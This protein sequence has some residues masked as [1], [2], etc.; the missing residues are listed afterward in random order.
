MSDRLKSSNMPIIGLFLFA[1]SL[2]SG[3]IYSQTDLAQLQSQTRVSFAAAQTTLT[4]ALFESKSYLIRTAPG[5]PPAFDPITITYIQLGPNGPIPPGPNPDPNPPGPT[6]TG[7]KG[8]IQAALAKVPANAKP[9]RKT[10]STL[11]NALAAEAAANPGTWDSAL[12]FN[13][14]K[15]RIATELSAPMLAAWQ[16][17]FKDEA[18][19]LAK[20]KIQAND[21]AAGIQA[22]TDITE[23]LDQ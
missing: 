4:I 10:I 19:A 17:Y 20:L 13:E 9:E 7:F 18:T 6:P 5:Q 2:G 1:I 11:Y 23:V 12:L 3:F 15:Q 22:L 16:P 14:K 8:E 21:L